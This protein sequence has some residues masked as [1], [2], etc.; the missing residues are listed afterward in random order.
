MS[1]RLTVIVPLVITLVGLASA[2][3]AWSQ[4]K[5]SQEALDQIA[6]LVAEKAARTSAEKKVSSALLL[7]D[8]RRA[9]HA[10]FQAAPKLTVDAGV[11]PDGRVLVDLGARVSVQLLGTIE[12]LGGEVV[13]S[14]IR[15]GAVRARLPLDRLLELARHGD[16]RTIRPADRYMTQS[17]G[18]GT[19]AVVTAGDVAHGTDVVRVNTGATGAGVGVGAMSDSVDALATL[20]GAGE[21]PPGVTVIPGQSGNPGSSEGTALLEIIHD[22]APGADLFFATG[23]GGQAQMAQN[24]IDL[25][26]AGCDVIV[27]DVTYF[28]EPVFQDG[29][30]AQA[31]DQVVAAGT[32][33]FSSAGNA[34]NFNDGES[35]VHEGT[36]SGTAPPTPLAG[37]LSVH[38]FD[39]GGTNATT[40]TADTPFLITL[41]WANPQGAAADDFDLFLLDEAL[42]NV[43]KA[44]TNVQD[45]TQDPFEFLDSFDDDDTGRKI[46]VAKFA[47]NDVFLHLN[48]HRGRIEHGTDGQIFGHAAAVGAMAV[49]AVNVAAA[50]GGQFAGGTGVMVQP[51]SSDG[52]RRIFFDADGSP[53]AAAAVGAVAEGDDPG[54]EVRDKPDLTAADGVSTATPGFDP[55]FGT[56]ASAPHSAGIS[57]LFRELFPGV[58]PFSAY[59]LFKSG[60]LDIEE[61]GSD[62][63]SGSGIMMPDESFG[64][65]IFSDGFESGDATAW[66]NEVP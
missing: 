35:G 56:S 61:L 57:A 48:T 50:G 1:P 37:Y 38:D 6:A 44:S 3:P 63:D 40:L 19:G 12:Q 59:D 11:E 22:M 10:L 41:Q 20:Q 31:V 58:E 28:Q 36:Y 52:P 14:H 2:G 54:G 23:A 21:L 62:R 33:Y 43:L 15:F 42:E 29:I 32:Y 18:G 47:G 45:G 5:I 66:T 30:I 65:V 9:G 7:E 64:N 46:V 60:A 49:A 17:S 26:A 4:D 25:Q 39:G 24:I 34:G 8:K 27:D 55:F 13:S 51:F 53:V 16:V